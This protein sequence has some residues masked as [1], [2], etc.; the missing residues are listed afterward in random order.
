MMS[1]PIV[2]FERIKAYEILKKDLSQDPQYL[3]VSLPRSVRLPLMGSLH[4]DLDKTILFI[5]SRTDRLLSMFEEFR[6]WAKNQ[7]HLIFSEPSPL[8]YEKA[9]WDEETKK[10]RLNT[11]T[12][13]AGLHIPTKNK[14]SNKRPVIFSSVKSIMTK[15][16]PLRNFIIN[17]K[18]IKIGDPFNIHEVIGGW[19]KTGYVPNEIVVT[20]GQFSKRGGLIDIWPLSQRDPIRIEL[21][22]DTIETLRTFDPS[23]QRSITTIDSMYIP[24]ARE[25]VRADLDNES[26][27]YSEYYI[28]QIYPS[29]GSL[30]DYLPKGSLIVLDNASSLEVTAEELELQAVKLREEMQIN[31]PEK[32]EFSAPYFSWSEVKD[33]LSRF[34]Q[35]D[36]GFP[37]SEEKHPISDAF[38]P[39]PRFGGH[40]EQLIQYIKK[41]NDRKIEFNI[42]SQQADRVR[43]QLTDLITVN[44]PKKQINLINGNVYGGW[45]TE[46]SDGLVSCLFSD[47][48]LFG[49]DQPHPHK[50]KA[51]AH[52]APEFSYADLNIGAYVVHVDYGIGEFAGLVHRSLDSID[53]DYLQIN[54]ADEGQLF[55]PVHQADRLSLYIGPDE[56]KPRLSRLG[57]GD[58]QIAKEKA[59]GA[60]KEVA[61]E[62]LELYAKRQTAQGFAYQGDTAWQKILE[63]SFPYDETDDQSQAIMEV[64]MD[65]ENQKPMDRLL[66]GDV[67]YGKTEVALRAAFK[68]VMDGRQVA[69]LVPTTVLAQQ[70]FDTFK[71]RLAPFPVEVEMLSRFRSQNEQENILA[72]LM[73]GEIDIVIGTHRLLQKD[74]CFKDLGLIIIDEEQ[75]FGVTHKE[76]FKS[77]RAEIDVLTLTATPIPRTL[78]M[79]LTGIRDISIINSPPSDRLPIQTYVGGYDDNIVRQ[80]ILREIDR[81]GQVFFVHNRVQTISAIA[82]RLQTIVPEAKI[83]IAHGQMPERELA[84]V[85]H[86]FS[87]GEVDVLISTSIIESGLDIPNANTLIVD[88]GDTFGLAQLYQLRGRVGR[89]ASKAYA[90]FFHHHQKMPSQEGLERLETIAENTQLGAGYSI[91]MRDLE[92]RGA[93]DLLGTMQHGYIAAIGF[94]LYT[95]L[96]AQAVEEVKKSG[97]MTFVPQIESSISQL[98]PLTTIELPFSVGIPSEYIPDEKLRLQI[99]RRLADIQVEEKIEE[100]KSEFTDRF[101]PIPQVLENLFTQLK[102]KLKAE[103]C[104]LASITLSGNN[105]MLQF[106]NISDGKPTEDFP[107]LVGSIRKGK[108][109][110][111]L[112]FNQ[113]EDW[114]QKIEDVLDMLINYVERDSSWNLN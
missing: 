107:D 47:G 33:H 41:R 90:Y 104:G 53:R 77:K 8:F 66:C 20:E 61:A 28:P 21:F 19:V 38:T 23:S 73:V 17:C 18:M 103:K 97:R 106:P 43:E 75:R 51:A 80:A 15:T 11:L 13:L 34:T 100:I 99:Y 70:H 64:K 56:R 50:R 45:I 78:Y 22:G 108:N 42:V 29:P 81:G 76:Y 71:G 44:D 62:L 88:R 84:T 36:L 96:L 48:E 57:S 4:A 59:R 63:S 55:V 85:M 114:I 101:G 83:N 87:A 25:A 79:A 54:Y 27:S 32:H 111:W 10:E 109:G 60:V 93:G 14:K 113:N 94:H 37:L 74:V 72:R 1:K 112:N 98:R 35:I 31:Y 86:R 5:T 40:I 91:A 65:M 39:S 68:A 110:Y 49:W 30:M 52:N 7:D 89:S 92:M 6:F 95:R 3:P 82:K 105:F 46:Y 24:P 58:W 9:A 2:D 26:L 16:I 67:G 102:I 69:M 12:I